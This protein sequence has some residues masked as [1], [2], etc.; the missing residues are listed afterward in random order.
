M[1]FPLK[2]AYS[3]YVL[4]FSKYSGNAW[5]LLKKIKECQKEETFLNCPLNS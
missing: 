1:V 3:N 4:Y 5:S 2:G